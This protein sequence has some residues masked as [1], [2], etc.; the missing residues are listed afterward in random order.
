MKKLNT[1]NKRVRWL[2]LGLLFCSLGAMA[3]THQ[4][5]TNYVLLDG[6]YKSKEYTKAIEPLD[7]L[8]TNSPKFHKNIYIK[9][10]NLYHKLAQQT[11]D[12]KLKKTYQDKALQIYDQRVK[13]FGEAPKVL[14]QKGHYAF[15]YWSQRP[16]K[17]EELFQLYKKIVKLN[18]NATYF[19]SISNY[20]YI[21]YQKYQKGKLKGPETIE[22][23]D[24]LTKIIEHNL[25]NNPKEKKDWEEVKKYVDDIFTKIA[26]MKGKY[27]K[28]PLLTCEFIEKY[29]M[30]LYNEN[31]ND[32]KIIK[33]IVDFIILV[34]R[35]NPAAPCGNSTTFVIL[36]EKL[37]KENPTF[38]NCEILIRMNLKLD[39]VEQAERLTYKLLE[40]AK[41]NKEK[42]K[43]NLAVAKLKRKKG[44]KIG[45]RKHALEVIKF[46][47]SKTAQMYSF[48]GE[49]YY[50]SGTICTHK[51]PV[52][53]RVAYM[54]AYWMHQK[55]GNTKG[56]AKSKAQCPTKEKA[57]TYGYAE[58]Q[59]IPVG[60]WIGGKVKLIT[61]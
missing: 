59:L 31:P 23:Y 20:M 52:L 5:K 28:P 21:V 32:I 41:N 17:E 1:V 13:H 49:L 16:D 24:Q 42:A 30:P 54:A 25:I 43:A 18:G 14:N 29:Y 34:R 11:Q 47:P 61:R 46:D 19:Q 26:L 37:F 4:E 8:L 60:C 48:I 33:K 6:Y 35:Q 45:A 40:L 10:Y 9:G 3:Q 15:Y 12:A 39:Y 55:A 22:I 27:G 7:W 50:N 53:A 56:M 51:N 2:W 38:R 57:F 58:G 44:D 36:N